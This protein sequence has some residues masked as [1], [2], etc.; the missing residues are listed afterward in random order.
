MGLRPAVSVIP[1]ISGRSVR[2]GKAWA[3]LEGKF[4][5]SA[6]SSALG[7][8]QEQARAAHSSGYIH[9]A[10]DVSLG[11]EIGGSLQVV[12]DA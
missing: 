6:R 10:G 5:A 7:C 12:R 8:G 2:V 9:G 1:V 3:R 11:M 4:V